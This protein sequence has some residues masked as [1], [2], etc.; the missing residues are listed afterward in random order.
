M[1]SK[2]LPRFITLPAAARLTGIGLGQ[3]RAAI[4]RGELN[5]VR[6]KPTGW[7]RLTVDEI[8]QWLQSHRKALH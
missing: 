5:P 8:E 4:E 3:F 1:D 2:R 7:P 6:F